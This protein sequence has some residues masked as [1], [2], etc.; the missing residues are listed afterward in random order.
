MDI[1]VGLTP[2]A[3]TTLILMTFGFVTMPSLAK[4]IA[5]PVAISEIAYGF[6]IGTSGMNLAEN[7]EEPYLKFLSQ[8]GFAFFLFLAGLEIDFTGIEKRLRELIL[9]FVISSMAFIIALLIGDQFEWNVWIVLAIGATSVPLLLAVVGLRLD[10][11]PLGQIMISVAAMGELV[12]IF[13][14]SGVDIY[15]KSNGELSEMINGFGL[16]IGL[17]IIAVVGASLLRMWQ[18]WQPKL[19]RQMIAHDDPSEIGI[20]VGFAMMFAFIGLSFK[21]HV[22][23]FLG[24]FIAGAILSFVIRDKGALEHKLS[25]MAY[26][27]FVPIFFI[28]VGMNLKITPQLLFNNYQ[29]I[30]TIIVVMGIVKF[31]PAVLLMLRGLKF[32]VLTTTCLLAAPS[33]WLFHRGNGFLE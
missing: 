29:T 23:P 14:L 33:P 4:R 27:F 30:L 8:L 25:S 19:F 1:T 21:A 11:S 12:T 13:A 28:D 22:E 2:T 5:I 6:I 15:E 7:N 9:P 16:L 18:W 26:G 31:V 17:V 20:R 10:T 3:A 24:A 32:Q